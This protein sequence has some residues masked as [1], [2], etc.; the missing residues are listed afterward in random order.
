MKW[1]KA[2]LAALLAL[3]LSGCSELELP[4][5]Q[6]PELLQ[7]QT[8]ET[9]EVPV[10]PAGV[11]V[12]VHTIQSRDITTDNRV[13]GS[14]VTE[15]QTSVYV[16][17][18]AKCTAV[19]V[20]EGDEIRR[21]A[22]I[23]KLDLAGTLSSYNAAQISYRSAQE[24]Y[25]AQK[26]IFDRQ[27]ALY[28]K[29][30]SDTKQLFEIGAASQL[31]ID[32]AELQVLTAIAQRE[33]TLSQLE[34]GMENYK[35]NLE[36]LAMVLDNVDGDGNVISPASGTIL[37]LSAEEGGMVTA[38]YPVAVI[39]GAQQ[40]KILVYVSES[41][42]PKIHVGDSVSATV[43]AAEL[44]FTGAVRKIDSTPNPQTRLYG[45]SIGVP[46]DAEGLVSGMFADVAF[47]TDA[48]A[49]AI[50]IPS[51]A[52]LTSNGQQFV[53]IVENEKA[54]RI[55]VTTGITGDGITEVLTG[56]SEGQ[57]LVTVGQQYLS[58]G[59]AVRIV[60]RED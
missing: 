39:S 58:D 26:E 19:Y 15:E 46:S 1:I 38:G 43:S 33:S 55:D 37:S 28:E 54:K 18:N 13:S 3:C 51:Q 47:H 14:I 56:L 50:V 44:D 24:S 49:G 48:S 20:K 32:T 34:A 25:D 52:L 21:G 12:Q 5:I 60:G 29:S 4:E 45:V 6:L 9:E 16:T 42:L 35:S 10:V 8:E 17:T 31:E 30:V 41:L 36:Q 40:L 2:M 27:I 23:C 11:A 53:Y 22:A 7:P 57:E 59:D